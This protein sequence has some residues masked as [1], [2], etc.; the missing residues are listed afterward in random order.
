MNSDEDKKMKAAIASSG[1]GHVARGMEAWAESLAEALDDTGVDVTLFRGAGPRKNRYDLIL[2]T[3][4]RNRWAAKFIAKITSK[5]GWRIGLGAP[6]TV[7]SFVYGIQLL[8]HLRNGYDIVHVQQGSLALFLQ[9]AIRMGLLHVPLI[10]GNGQKAPPEFIS[11]FPNVHFLSPY[12]KENTTQYVKER[13][14]WCVIPNFVDTDVFSPMEKTAC[15]KKFGLPNNCFIVLTVGMIDRQTK[16]MDYF[17]KEA[18]ALKNKASQP[19]HFVVAGSSHQD[20]P[21]IMGLGKRLLDNNVTFFLDLPRENMPGLYNS[22]DVFV[23]CSF[24]EAMPVALIEAMA[25]RLP[26]ICHNFPILKWVVQNGGDYLDLSREHALANI[27]RQ[28]CNDANLVEQKGKI[29]RERVLREFST[30]VVVSKIIGMYKRV[31]ESNEVL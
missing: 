12:D 17:L 28:Y 30:P 1:L 29:A 5:G 16:R 13:P 18:A 21:S 22:S 10:F 26:A 9:R 2:P 3:L 24:R 14:G 4:K 27:L 8:Y 11:F 19:I 23:L 6:H 15:R 31:I 7:E 25:C 20:T